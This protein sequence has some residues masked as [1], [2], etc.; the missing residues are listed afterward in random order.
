LKERVV[1]LGAGGHA[2]VIVD[3]LEGIGEVDIAG[4][5]SPQGTQETLCGYPRLGTDDDLDEVLRSGVRFAFAAVGENERR[6]ACIHLLRACGFGLI[7]VISPHAVVSARAVLGRGVAVLPGA[8]INAAARISD[9]VIVN[10]NASVD[11]DCVIGACAHIAPGAVVAGCVRL[12]DGVLLGVGSRVIPG[13]LIGD[14]TT[15]GAG[16]VVVRDVAQH[17]V[18]MG[19]PATVRRKH[20]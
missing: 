2:R 8:I 4:F 1:I 3:V 5:A 10:T 17:V 20:D 7:N 6:M 14:G 18:A 13:V 15:I 12:G 19:V 16:A 9:G 11:H